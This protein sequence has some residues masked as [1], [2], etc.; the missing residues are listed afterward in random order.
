MKH[1]LKIAINVLASLFFLVSGTMQAAQ[2]EEVWLDFSVPENDV[3]LSASTVSSTREAAS[4]EAIATTRSL[5]ASENAAKLIALDFSVSN[6][7]SAPITT[8]FS[9][10][11]EPNK[12]EVKPPSAKAKQPPTAKPSFRPPTN[13]AIKTPALKPRSGK[14]RSQQVTAL[15]RAI[16]GQESAGNF[17]IVNPDS[18]ALGYGQLLRTNVGPWTKAALGRALT[19]EEF[20]ANPNAQIRTIDHKLNEYLQ[21]ELAYTGGQNQELAIRRVASRWYSGNPNLWNNTRPQYSNGR[22]YPSI[23]SYTRSVWQR[24][25]REIG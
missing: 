3:V 25:L 12:I 14:T 24:Y 19:P 4:T 17:W 22:R 5:K 7:D 10:K 9:G 18:G 15:R 20:L 6:A 8:E 2:A 16:I 11:T 1:P 21:R 13:A 23:A